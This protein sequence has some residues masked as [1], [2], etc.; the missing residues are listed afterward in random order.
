MHR[1]GGGSAGEAV[2]H[3]RTHPRQ[4]EIAD[5]LPLGPSMKVLKRELRRTVAPAHEA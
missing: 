3:G 1:A 5:G 4:V 2:L